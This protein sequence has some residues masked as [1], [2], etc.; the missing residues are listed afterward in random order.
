MGSLRALTAA[1]VVFCLQDK[2]G[3]TY[4]L[5]LLIRNKQ[6]YLQVMWAYLEQQSFPMDLEDYVMHLN[7]VLEVINR[8]GN[9]E[10]VREWL[11]STTGKPRVGRPLIL[12]L[13]GRHLDEFVL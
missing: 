4:D 3:V 12:N 1:E 2:W 9:S 10:I 11:A 5:R 6:L 8:S 13:G 7:K